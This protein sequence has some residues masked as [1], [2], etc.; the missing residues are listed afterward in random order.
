MNAGLDLRNAILI[1]K[2]PNDLLKAGIQALAES[3]SIPTTSVTPMKSD[4]RGVNLILDNDSNFKKIILKGYLVISNEIYLVYPVVTDLAV[5]GAG[6]NVN[7]ATVKY[8]LEPF[9]PIL[10]VYR[11]KNNYN[12]A[13]ARNYRAT[14]LHPEIPE[15]IKK[16]KCIKLNSNTIDN[17]ELSITFFCR[18]C[19][20]YGHTR[21]ECSTVKLQNLLNVASLDS[22]ITSCSN[23]KRLT[24]TGTSPD[25]SSLTNFFPKIFQNSERD[26]NEKQ[27][28]H[29][30]NGT[31]FRISEQASEL[32][33]SFN[34]NKLIPPS[35]K[36][37]AIHL[38]KFF[39][40]DD[41]L[42][43]PY[44][45]ALRYPEGINR[46]FT[47]LEY[48]GKFNKKYTEKRSPEEN[49]FIE[50]LDIMAAKIKYLHLLNISKIEPQYKPPLEEIRKVQIGNVNANPEVEDGTRKEHR[51]EEKNQKTTN[52]S[53]KISKT[54]IS[55]TENQCQDK[56]ENSMQIT[57]NK[58]DKSDRNPLHRKSFPISGTCS[59]KSSKSFCQSDER[60]RPKCSSE[61][62]KYNSE[63][64]KT[65]VQPQSIKPNK[66]FVTELEKPET[67]LID[68]IINNIYLTHNKNARLT[69]LS[70][71]N[72]QSISSV[73]KNNNLL[74]KDQH[75][76]S[77]T[78]EN[79]NVQ[80]I[81]PKQNFYSKTRN[82]FGSP[83]PKGEP[84]FTAK[85]FPATIKRE[86]NEPLLENTI[87]EKKSS[88]IM[89]SGLLK[90][91][92]KT[93][94]NEEQIKDIKKPLDANL[95][96]VKSNF[97]RN[98]DCKTGITETLKGKHTPYIFPSGVKAAIKRSKG[99]LKPA[100]MKAFLIHVKRRKYPRMY[101]EIYDK[102]V[103]KIIEQLELIVNNY[104]HG[105]NRSKS[106]DAQISWI[107]QL[108]KNLK[109]G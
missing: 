61:A 31:E 86:P 90:K 58:P 105:R 85:N 23:I 73:Q 102:D 36:N 41:I 96:D 42:E 46:F 104:Y 44:K 52:R 106:D 8:L 54:C 67:N 28:S 34:F 80:I 17:T 14:L 98:V 94:F 15:E 50:W 37:D 68:N 32:L 18:F 107:M 75:T 79:T 51:T 7:E 101:A 57:E 39:L 63:V 43:S 55:R 25:N 83:N 40:E 76:T 49:K 53:S 64:V 2:L 11:E 87:F 62:K 5:C 109:E 24:K 6:L 27:V 95:A 10:V 72:S 84:C 66:P 48:L 99:I 20:Q 26:L 74:H 35:L 81:E 59:S 38:K 100:I 103:S 33:H 89:F 92:I 78:N 22:T 13:S 45:A 82:E 9:A 60:N 88:D 108:I 77:L 71:K 19:R 29:Q 4:N 30:K 3:I 1:H 93:E 70:S 56:N 69:E 91:I 47:V 16:W 21:H 65:R 12:G 97:L